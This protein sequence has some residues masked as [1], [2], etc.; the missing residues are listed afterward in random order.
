MQA[1]LS[2][3]HLHYARISIVRAPSFAGVLPLADTLL[4]S[5]RSS[6]LLEERN[7]AD[8][9]PSDARK[10][11]TGAYRDAISDDETLG[12]AGGNADGDAD[13]GAVVDALGNTVGAHALF[14]PATSIADGSPNNE[15]IQ[16][17]PGDAISFN[18]GSFRHPPL[19]LRFGGPSVTR[20]ATVAVGGPERAHFLEFT[21]VEIEW[22]TA[23]P[24]SFRNC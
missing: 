20:D 7:R 19:S 24:S 6:Q 13:G 11:S 23:S 3:E 18:I 5:I 4:T 17:S 8:D 16:Q 2:Y 21:T 12:A 22:D 14:A 9:N 1:F 15:E 10:S